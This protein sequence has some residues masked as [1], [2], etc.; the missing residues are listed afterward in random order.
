MLQVEWNFQLIPNFCLTLIRL[1][2]LPS[3]C[4]WL[5]THIHFAF[6]YIFFSVLLLF[7]P[8]FC[9]SFYFPSFSFSLPFLLFSCLSFFHTCPVYVITKL[10]NT[11][12]IFI[13][14]FLLNSSFSVSKQMG[15]FVPTTI[16]FSIIIISWLFQADFHPPHSLKAAYFFSFVDT[17]R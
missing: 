13:I 6:P 16:L 5:L 11:S 15:Y 14:F 12:V 1:Y 17:H 4:L 9:L 7:S 2:G 3:L 8:F 10:K